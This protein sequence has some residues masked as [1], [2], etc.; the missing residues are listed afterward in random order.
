MEPGA[1]GSRNALRGD[2]SKGSKPVFTLISEKTA[3]NFE[4]LDRKTPSVEPGTYPSTSFE[5]RTALPLVEQIRKVTIVQ[6]SYEIY[7]INKI[8]GQELSKYVRPFASCFSP[9]I[10]KIT[11]LFLTILKMQ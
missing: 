1:T 10:F 2:L 7:L 3:E 11:K 4:R 9:E 6:E 5:S 8:L